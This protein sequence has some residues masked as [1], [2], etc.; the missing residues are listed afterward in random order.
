MLK[1]L[2]INPRLNKRN[3]LFKNKSIIISFCY[4]RSLHLFFVTSALTSSFSLCHILALFSSFSCYLSFDS[5]P[6]DLCIV[7]IYFLGIEISI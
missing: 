4:I 2:K 6:F 1:D 7:K 3:L 5:E